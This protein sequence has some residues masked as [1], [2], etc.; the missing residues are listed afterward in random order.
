MEGHFPRNRRDSRNYQLDR[1][2]EPLVMASEIQGLPDLR[3]YLKSSNLVWCLTQ[4]VF[5]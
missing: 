1:T 3:A 5:Y 4:I 2:T